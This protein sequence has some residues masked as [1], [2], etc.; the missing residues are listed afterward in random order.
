MM[1][2]L[3]QYASHQL[4]GDLAKQAPRHP[5]SRLQKEAT[6]ESTEARDS[7]ECTEALQNTN[8]WRDANKR[9]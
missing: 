2:C 8:Y 7:T 6:T 5:I 3:P 4:I 1:P 9:Y